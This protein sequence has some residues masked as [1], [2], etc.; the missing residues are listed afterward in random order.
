[1]VV[2]LVFVLLVEEIAEFMASFRFT[3][4]A[5]TVQVRFCGS[6]NV[7]LPSTCKGSVFVVW[8]QGKRK[9]DKQ[10]RNWLGFAREYT[11]TDTME[12]SFRP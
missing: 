1:M 7:K 8:Y 3:D 10:H 11:N 9:R 6:F 12:Y 4:A 2:V 5:K